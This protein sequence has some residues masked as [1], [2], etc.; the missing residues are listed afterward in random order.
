[1][2]SDELAQLT[3]E[4]WFAV[5][6][7]AASHDQA[8]RPVVAALTHAG[9]EPGRCLEQAADVVRSMEGEVV[10]W[11]PLLRSAAW[12]LASACSSAPRPSSIISGRCCASVAFGHAPSWREIS[13]AVPPPSR[14]DSRPSADHAPSVAGAAASCAPTDSSKSRDTRAYSSRK[15]RQ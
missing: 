10:F 12:Q 7:A 6:L 5:R 15:L 11:H 1:V 8:A 13:H 4:A 3:S 9:L 14:H 2:Y